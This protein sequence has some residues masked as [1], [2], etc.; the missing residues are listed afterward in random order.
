MRR[1]T[2]RLLTLG[3][4]DVV[5]IV[6]GGGG[7]R[8]LAAL[9]DLDR[10]EL[11]VA[12]PTD[13]A[14]AH[15]QGKVL[16]PRRGRSRG[17]PPRPY[18]PCTDPP[19]GRCA[20]HDEDAAEG[21]ATTASALHGSTARGLDGKVTKR[22]EREERKSRTSRKQGGRPSRARPGGRRHVGRGVFRR[23]VGERKGRCA[24]A[25]TKRDGKCKKKDC[26]GSNPGCLGS[27][28]GS[29]VRE[30]VM[31]GVRRLIHRIW[32]VRYE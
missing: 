11:L 20:A 14:C 8:A 10:V 31:T 16:R 23:R 27:G 21:S 12:P 30:W 5:R 6:D 32:T 1:E 17:N 26:E 7:S 29:W 22:E 18:P 19:L 15:L 25:R 24:V 28:V 4:V 3:V 2:G 13:H 9:G